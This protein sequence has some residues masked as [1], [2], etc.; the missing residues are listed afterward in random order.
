MQHA[1]RNRSSVSV[2]RFKSVIMPALPCGQVHYLRLC[3]WHANGLFQV[4][5]TVDRNWDI[6]FNRRVLTLAPWRISV[7]VVVHRAATTIT[8]KGLDMR[9]SLHDRIQNQHFMRPGNPIY[10]RLGKEDTASIRCNP[11][12]MREEKHMHQ[13]NVRHWASKEATKR[14]RCGSYRSGNLFT[15]DWTCV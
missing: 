13:M 15:L 11:Y 12:T 5:F 6:A 8:K 14:L 2:P 4:M 9:H 3:P 1:S 10:I 7:T